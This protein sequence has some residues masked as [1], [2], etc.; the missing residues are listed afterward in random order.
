MALNLEPQTRRCLETLWDADI[1]YPAKQAILAKVRA[2]PNGKNLRLDLPYAL[3]VGANSFIELRYFYENQQVFF[4]LYDLPD[5]L[6]NVIL[7]RF[8]S[9]GL[10]RPA[11][12]GLIR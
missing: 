3:N 12:K 11:P 2:L 7:E 10:I 5:L 1:R 8:P 6:R 9:W 4:L